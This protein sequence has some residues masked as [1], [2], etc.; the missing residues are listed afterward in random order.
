MNERIALHC[1]ALPDTPT[2]RRVPFITYCV[3]TLIG[4]TPLLL[5][6]VTSDIHSIFYTLATIEPRSHMWVTGTPM[7]EA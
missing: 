3:A 1:I 4:V 5:M 2:N 7:S 6:Y